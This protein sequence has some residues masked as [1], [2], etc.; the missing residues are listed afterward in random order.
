VPDVLAAWADRN[1]C[2]DA[3][4]TEDPI[5][6]D[7]TLL[8]FA[9]PEGAEVELYRVEGGGHTWPGA[10]MLRGATDVVGLT[11]FSISANEIMWDFFESHPLR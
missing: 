7:V 1:G 3:D 2:D 10:E 11:T 4:P 8:S 5:A 9:C 6:E